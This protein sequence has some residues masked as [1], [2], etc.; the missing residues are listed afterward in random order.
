MSRFNFA[1]LYISLTLQLKKCRKVVQEFSQ[2]IQELKY[3]QEAKKEAFVSNKALRLQPKSLTPL[4]PCLLL[5]FLTGDINQITN[6]HI[7]HLFRQYYSAQKQT[8][9]S[10]IQDT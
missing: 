2:V 1:F 10:I 5:H 3:N 7:K 6:E 4:Q 8:M 9:A